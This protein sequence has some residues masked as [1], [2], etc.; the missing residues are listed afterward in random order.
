MANKVLQLTA[1]ESST[2]ADDEGEDVGAAFRFEARETAL[3]LCDEGQTVEIL[4][5]D[6]TV[7]DS[8]TAYDG[9]DAE[10]A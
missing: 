10:G 5:A 1:A 6:G 4:D 3:A 7:L 8:L 9:D 2:W